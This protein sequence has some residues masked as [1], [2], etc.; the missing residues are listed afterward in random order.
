MRQGIC[1]KCQ[2]DNVRKTTPPPLDKGKSLVG[3]G[4]FRY[5]RL[6]DYICG[7]C[8]YHESYVENSADLQ[9]VIDCSERV[10]VSAK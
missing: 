1:P 3:L 8:G 2:A 7:D 5:C 9:A 4:W 6:T 10:P